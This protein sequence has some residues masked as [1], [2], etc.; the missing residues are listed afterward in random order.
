VAQAF[1]ASTEYH[2]R[3]VTALYFAD[4]TA[5]STGA[6]PSIAAQWVGSTLPD[7]LHR[8]AAPATAEIAGWVNSG[9]DVLRIEASIANSSE[10]FPSRSEPGRAPA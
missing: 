5:G 1:L 10:F 6:L 2:S 4:P 9:L 7:L 3:A 8:S